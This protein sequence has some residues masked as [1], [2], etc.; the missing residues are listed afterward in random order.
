MMVN[1]TPKQTNLT[2]R[3]TP[4]LLTDHITLDEF[5]KRP[6]SMKGQRWKHIVVK[7]R[8]EEGVRSCEEMRLFIGKEGKKKV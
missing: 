2:P 8:G 5:S 1:M 6:L 7:G 4:S 3:L